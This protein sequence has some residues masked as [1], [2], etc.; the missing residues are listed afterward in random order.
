MYKKH[1]KIIVNGAENPAISKR[2]LKRKLVDNVSDIEFCRSPRANEPDRMYS[3][4]TKTTAIDD[5]DKN[6][7]DANKDMHIVFDCA[8]II[9]HDIATS[10][11]QQ[12][13]KF[14]GS[15]LGQDHVPKSLETLIR[16]ILIGP[17]SSLESTHREQS[18]ELLARTISQNIMFAYKSDRQV[19][20]TPK[21]SS[22]GFRH[23]SENP[24]V[25]GIGLKV[26]Q[27]TRSKAEVDMLYRFGYSISYERVL[28]I[29]TQLAA[30]VLKQAAQ[31]NGI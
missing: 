24:Q 16:W 2:N 23:Q 21:Q 3:S 27:A 12:P 10:H 11:K 9:R 25:V 30:A 18:V 15:L 8:K 22:S 19:S 29:E 28:R 6:A 1:T 14:A 17:R 7:R 13:W 4:K 31:N 26:H 20:Y 5:F